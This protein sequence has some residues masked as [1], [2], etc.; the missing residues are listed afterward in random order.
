MRC[1]TL[2]FPSNNFGVLPNSFLDR[3]ALIMKHKSPWLIRT[4]IGLV[5]GAFACALAATQL[6][7]PAQAEDH[8]V[9]P[10][11]ADQAPGGR[12]LMPMHDRTG[13]YSIQPEDKPAQRTPFHLQPKGPKGDD[14]WRLTLENKAATFFQ[15]DPDGNIMIP[16][17][18][19]L[20]ENVE[21][22]YTPA[23]KMLPG[24]WPKGLVVEGD[25]KMLVK[26]IKTGGVREKGHCKY[27][28]ELLGRQRVST[29]AGDFDTYLV[30]ETRHIFLQM[31]KADSICD[32][33]YVAEK[34]D[35]KEHTKERTKVFGLFGGWHVEDCQLVR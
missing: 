8:P 7:T 22:T 25:V 30:R 27:R 32:T 35:V 10:I 11:T 2:R 5:L 34:G 21:M 20:G 28:V 12:D 16:C 31:A 23:L 29:P 24:Q 33:W 13:E 1:G 4:A 9:Q 14:L 6:A 18:D 3:Y 26:N 17:E 15:P 19:D